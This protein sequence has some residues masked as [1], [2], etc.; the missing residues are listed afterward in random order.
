MFQGETHNSPSALD[1]YGGALTGI[2]GVN[3]DILGSGLGARPIFN[4]DIFCLPPLSLEK[5]HFG[6][7]PKTVMPPKRLLEGVHLGVEDGGNK[8]GIPTVSGAMIFDRSYAGKPLIFVGTA[9]VLPRKIGGRNTFE[10][11]AQDGDLIYMV[12]GSVGI[13]GIHGATFSSM[14]LD[15]KAPATAVQIGDPFTQK[16]M[17][18]FLLEARDRCLF[19]SITD[20]G[21][22]GLSSSVGEMACDCGG[23]V[24][25]LERIP[26]KYPGL[27][28]WEIIVS[29]SQERMTLAVPEENRAALE[30]LSK[31][32]AVQAV[33]I[34][35]FES[36]GRFTIK[37]RGKTTAQIAMDFLHGGI[38]KDG[39]KARWDGPKKQENPYPLE[40]RKAPHDLASTL[41]ALF[42]S[43][44]IASKEHWV[45]RYDHEVQGQTIVKPFYRGKRNGP[46]DGGVVSLAGHG[47]EKD[48]AVAVGHGLNPF[49]SEVD[50]YVMAMASVDECV[51]NLLCLGGDLDRMALLDNFC[52]PNPLEDEYRLGQLV[53]A[54]EGL[55][56]TCLAYNLPLISGK[57]SMKNDY[58]GLSRLGR[59][60]SFSVLPTLL[61][62]GMA[63]VCVDNLIPSYAFCDGDWLVE[64][65]LWENK[66]WGAGAYTR[67]FEEEGGEDKAPP[68]HLSQQIETLRD[69]E[70]LRNKKLITALHDVSDGGVAVAMAEML[71][72]EEKG[73]S[74]YWKEDERFPLFS[75]GLCCFTACVPPRH[76]KQVEE[77]MGDRVKVWGQVNHSGLLKWKG[78]ELGVSEC[79][80]CWDRGLLDEYAS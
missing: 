4:T 76:L 63:S 25:D 39:L 23:A 43:P 35:H 55:Y 57:D 54:C 56:D 30:E 79:L 52:W 68:C 50:P 34:G 64:L 38:P 78:G 67:L 66:S 19:R 14:E 26:L 3:R 74:L 18:D 12:G 71:F 7:L 41:K 1:P 33:C 69:I 73:A 15:D 65:G 45:R 11:K 31:R 22:G 47:G 16:I 36:S 2:L 77:V 62:S 37:D 17:A 80:R 28:P 48:R 42:M 46:A 24:I 53:R 61:I 6:D 20:N 13:D 9:G 27:S 21:A 29:E 49:L 70:A 44:N 10:K 32:Y 51:R 40:R 75:E 8:S 5:T 59:P 58:R 60:L 72:V